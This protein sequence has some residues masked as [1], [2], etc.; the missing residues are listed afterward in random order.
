MKKQRSK[1]T[2]MVVK[3]SIFKDVMIGLDCQLDWISNQLPC[4]WVGL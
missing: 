4:F 3:L 2:L 1:I